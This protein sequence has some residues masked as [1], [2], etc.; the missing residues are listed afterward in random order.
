MEVRLAVLRTGRAFLKTLF[1]LLLVLISFRGCGLKDYVNFD[2]LTFR[3]VAYCLNHLRYCAPLLGLKPKLKHANC[4]VYSLT[5]ESWG[6]VM[7]MMVITVSKQP[8]GLRYHSCP[9]VHVPSLE[10]CGPLVNNQ[11]GATRSGH[12]FPISYLKI[13]PLYW[14]PCSRVGAKF[15]ERR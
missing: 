3:L 12:C 1:F 7:V 13:N 15:K 10:A 9:C 6:T 2:L 14:Q 11:R 5:G 8:N 4:S